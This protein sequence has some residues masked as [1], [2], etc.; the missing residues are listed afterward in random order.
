MVNR[1]LSQTRESGNGLRH[2]HYSNKRPVNIKIQIAMQN[3][4]INTYYSGGIQTHDFRIL[5]K[6]PWPPNL[7]KWPAVLNVSPTADS[8]GDK[9]NG[10]FLHASVDLDEFSWGLVLQ[11][12]W[13]SEP[14]PAS[15]AEKVTNGISYRE[16]N[17]H[18][19]KV[20]LGDSPGTFIIQNPVQRWNISLRNETTNAL[21]PCL[22][23][24]RPERSR[25]RVPPALKN[26]KSPKSM[27]ACCS[28]KLM[29]SSPD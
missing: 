1:H 26:F 14:F 19:S 28:Y 11:R 20:T 25:D 13:T 8:H 29:S 3:S 27:R 16:R 7:N 10:K 5:R 4:S 23:L 22:E 18:D 17:S 15:K 12:P 2:T 24:E 9:C 21:W 6:A